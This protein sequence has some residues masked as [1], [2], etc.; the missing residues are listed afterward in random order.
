MFPTR[1]DLHIAPF[2]DDAMYIEHFSK[3]NFWYVFPN[4]LYLFYTYTSILFSGLK[5]DLVIV[6][7]N[8]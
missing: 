5:P 6:W 8:L 3:A 1:G 7:V 4:T 2:T